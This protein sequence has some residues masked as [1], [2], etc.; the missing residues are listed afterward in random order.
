MAKTDVWEMVVEAV[1]HLNKEVSISEIKKYINSKWDNVHQGTIEAQIQVLTVNH[2][3]R[4]NFP[5]N[6][7]PRLTNSGSPYDHLFR[8][9]RGRYMKYDL[10]KHGIWEIFFNED[11]KKNAVRKYG[12]VQGNRAFLFTWNPK[13]YDWG[14]L[15]KLIMQIQNCGSALCNWQ[16]T[17]Y[18]MIRPGDRAFFMCL[19][20]VPKGIFGSG[21]VKSF[22]FKARDWDQ[23]AGDI[24]VV[25]I[26][27]E[28]LFDPRT[29]PILE[30]DRLQSGN[31]ANQTWT[32]QGSN[33]SIKNEF[34]KELEELWF[35]CLNNR[36][37]FSESSIIANNETAEVYM[38]GKAAEVVQTRYERNPGAREKCLKHFGYMCS[39]CEFDFEKCFGDIG[40]QFI[41]VHHL[42]LIS[43]PGQTHRVDPHADL[44]PVCPNC[45]AMLHKRNPPFTLEELKEKMTWTLQPATN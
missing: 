35:D 26:E 1:D 30:L 28:F 15:P 13:K 36:N 2:D 41:H 25:S 22:P 21:Y 37:S 9:D 45:H 29:Q 23:S 10:K 6:N 33:I 24:F 34:V 42:K 4:V 31:L 32:P 3:S 40:K 43:K 11:K 8:L 14:E 19:G 38:E 27:F 18:N 39:V 44:R 16:C 7:K 17:S 5:Q 12:V 20:V